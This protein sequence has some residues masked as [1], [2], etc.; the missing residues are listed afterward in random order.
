L[1]QSPRAAGANRDLA[2]GSLIAAG[3]ATL[4]LTGLVLVAALAG[5]E[6][7]SLGTGS[8][9][10]GAALHAP[11]S[12]LAERDIP[13]RYLRLYQ[14]AAQRFGLDWAVLAGIGK[15][16]C[17][18]G[19]DPDPSCTREGA[20]NSAGAGGPMQFLASTWKTYGMDGN[21]DGKVNRWDPSDAIFAAANYLRASGAPDDYHRAIL[22]YNRAEWYV[23]DVMRWA[24]RYRSSAVISTVAAVEGGERT[25]EWSSNTPIRFV[26]GERALL[27][28]QDARV[29]LVPNDVPATVQAMVVAGNELQDLPYGPRWSSRS[30]RCVGRGLFEHRQLRALP[31]RGAADTGN[32]R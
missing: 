6:G 17:D 1:T 19:R 4:V 2:R 23:A 28:P 30:P 7:S 29:A 22:A 9:Y 32:Y 31:L 5:L 27:D 14:Q 8:V 12:A 25:S 16:E 11:V 10:G 15:V 18:H 13:A 24:A 20:V 3:A 21:G 26:A